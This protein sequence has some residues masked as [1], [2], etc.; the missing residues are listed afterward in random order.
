MPVTTVL[1]ETTEL[2]TN[3][4]EGAMVRIVIVGYCTQT[5]IVGLIKA[6]QQLDDRTL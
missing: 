5:C 6:E 2:K 1:S 4:Y 3:S